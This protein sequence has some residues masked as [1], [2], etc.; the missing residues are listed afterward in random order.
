MDTSTTSA[1]APEIG[2]S[3]SRPLSP[4]RVAELSRPFRQFND[5]ARYKRDSRGRKRVREHE[6]ASRTNWTHPFL[7]DQID[8]AAREV[9]PAFSPT[10]IVRRLQQRNPNQFL[11]LTSQVVGRWI[12]RPP[13]QPPRWKESVRIRAEQGNKP[14]ANMTSSSVLVCLLPS[15]TI[16][17]LFVHFICSFIVPPL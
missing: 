4:S 3:D 9:I 5:E 13:H 6:D 12:E 16:S 15:P 17:L 8:T 10:E 2:D 14:I 7:F 11:P 1:C